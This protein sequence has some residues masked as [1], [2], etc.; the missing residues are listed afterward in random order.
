M[1][2]KAFAKGGLYVF[3]NQDYESRIRGGHTFVQVRVRNE[4][5]YTLSE[6]VNMLIALNKET[7]DLHKNE[8]VKGGVIIFDGEKI[9]IKA[10][11]NY[12]SV[13][14]EKLALEKGG[15]KIMINTVATGAAMGMLDYDFNL[16]TDVLSE[17]FGRKGKGVVES[18]VKAARAG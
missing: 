18:N 15:S 16:L 9:P 5:V 2:S 7:I 4:P 8:L 17:E 1:L 11:D 13:P 12:Y 14:L 6:E 3:L 10:E